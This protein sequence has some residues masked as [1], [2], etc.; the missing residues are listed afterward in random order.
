MNKYLKIGFITRPHGVKGE[1]KI[2]PLTDEVE[3][4]KNLKIIYLLVDG[5]YKEQELK[6]VK[7][8]HN[9]VIVKFTDYNDRNQVEGLRN[10]YI[11]IDKKDGIPLSVDEY[12]TQDLEECDLYH[13]EKF[14]GKVTNVINEGSCDIFVIDFSGKEVLYPFL[15]KYIE[16]IDIEKRKIYIKELEGYFD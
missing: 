1:I 5:K 4:F 10:S 16:K 12:Y 6:S 13:N 9:S 3:R 15:K 14:I 2:L 11:Y 7:I 8:T